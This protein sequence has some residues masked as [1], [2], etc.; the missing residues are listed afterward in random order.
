[1]GG[2]HGIVAVKRL[3]RAARNVD[4][5]PAARELN[6]QEMRVYSRRFGVPR[7]PS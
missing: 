2:V 1:M 5:G 7:G 3:K 4:E 6:L